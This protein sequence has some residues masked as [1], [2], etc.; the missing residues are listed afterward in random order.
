MIRDDMTV[1]KG[2]E[3]PALALAGVGYMP[4]KDEK[5]RGCFVWW[6]CGLRRG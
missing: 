6:Q 2:L 3:F 1:S 5:R 4:A